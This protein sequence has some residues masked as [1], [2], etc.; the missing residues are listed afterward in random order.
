M[1]SLK[2]YI[3][4]LD[5]VLYLGRQ[6][7]PGARD[8]IKQLRAKGKRVR[9]L[10]IASFRSRKSIA[11]KLSSMG[12]RCS[13]DEVI[14]SSH[15]AAHYIRQRYGRCKVFVVGERGLMKEMKSFG[16]RT[17]KQGARVVL[18]G[19]DRHINYT[20][21]ADALDLLRAGADFL[22]CNDDATYPVENRILPGAGAM[23]SSLERAS[24]RRALVIGKPNPFIMRMCLRSLGLRASQVAVVGDRLETDILMA[25]KVRAFSIL[26]LTGVSDRETLK[27]ARGRLRPKLVVKNLHE[28]TR[29]L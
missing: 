10:S 29:K 3:L 4:D 9:F 24:G 19:L 26:V 5:G 11:R 25:N 15:A 20:K 28:L 2:G 23:V 1:R 22:A 18:V 7:I 8:F 27:K 16:L 12:I 21:L 14:N 6:P 13:E 17:G